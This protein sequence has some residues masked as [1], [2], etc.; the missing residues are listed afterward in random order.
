MGGNAGFTPVDNL[1]LKLKI[2]LDQ[3]ARTCT[4]WRMAQGTKEWTTGRKR[5]HEAARLAF[6]TA[7]RGK[8][9]ML[10]MAQIELAEEVGVSTKTVNTIEYGHNWPSLPLYIAICRALKCGKIPLIS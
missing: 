9:Q 4:V 10:H 5:E 2:L 1:F 7:L 3:N 6:G 8:R